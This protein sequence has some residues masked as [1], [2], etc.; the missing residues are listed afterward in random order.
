[1][2]CRVFCFDLSLLELKYYF[3]F[4]DNN[5]IMH[6]VGRS[7][8]KNRA[9]MIYVDRTMAQA[10]FASSN[11]PHP[12]LYDKNLMHDLDHCISGIY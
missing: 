10:Y 8:K 1:M 9:I 4:W 11:L 3:I 7:I 12:L 5:Q 2:T 6:Y